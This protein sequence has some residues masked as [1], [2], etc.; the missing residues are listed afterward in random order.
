V[1]QR[2]CEYIVKA[3]VLD[4]ERLKNSFIKNRTNHGAGVPWIESDIELRARSKKN[5]LTCI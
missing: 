4:D 3:F 1:T 2:L 5:D